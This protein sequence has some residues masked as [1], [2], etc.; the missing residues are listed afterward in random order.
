MNH[1]KRG[2]E[3][4]P[5][6]CTLY[7]DEFQHENFSV[8]DLFNQLRACKSTHRTRRVRICI[9]YL[10][11][12]QLENFSVP[13]MFNQFRACKSTHRTIRV[14][15]CNL[16][17]KE[18]QHENLSVSPILN[19]FIVQVNPQNKTDRSKFCWQKL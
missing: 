6:V 7:L 15:D 9:L 17:L 12:F 16:Y 11:E 19:Q 14:V 4:S 10:D 8:P 3:S 2:F 1:S 18:F 13:D 5:A